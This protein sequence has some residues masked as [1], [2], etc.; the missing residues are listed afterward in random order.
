MKT[1]HLYLSAFFILSIF[2]VQAQWITQGTDICARQCCRSYR[3]YIQRLRNALY[4]FL[5]W[6]HQRYTRCA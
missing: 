6:W 1:L 2:L 5:R 4:L 3:Y